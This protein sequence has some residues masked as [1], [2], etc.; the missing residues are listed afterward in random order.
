MGPLSTEEVAREV[1]IGRSTLELW[2]RQGK[3]NPK[4][5]QIGRKNYRVWTDREI[6]KV[7]AVKRKTYRKRRTKNKKKA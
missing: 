7:I 3:L 5:L 6:E 2:I 4:V 1:G